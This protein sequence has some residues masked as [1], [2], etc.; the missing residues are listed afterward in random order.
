MKTYP[1]KKYGTGKK[2]D[3]IFAHKHCNVC[4]RMVPE[5]GDGFCS[6][7]CRDYGTNKGK[8]SKKKLIRNIV[9]IAIVIV[10]VI[11]LFIVLSP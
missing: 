5:W 7:R 4:G 10:A 9:S 1:R 8:S 2:S 3:K 6:T 11:V